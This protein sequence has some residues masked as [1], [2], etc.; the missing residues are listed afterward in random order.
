MKYLFIQQSDIGK[1]KRTVCKD[2]RK[3]K[4]LASIAIFGVKEIELDNAHARL[5]RTQWINF[6]ER[7]KLAL[8]SGA[9]IEWREY[10]P[11]P[12]EGC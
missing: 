5:F 2:Q 11:T 3:L 6:Y 8:N 10:F 7:K 9:T 1:P 12:N 4:R